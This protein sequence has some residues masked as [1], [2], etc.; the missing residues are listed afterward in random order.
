MGHSALKS[1]V[2][3]KVESGTAAGVVS[4]WM[5]PSGAD[6]AEYFPGHVYLHCPQER[7]DWTSGC[8]LPLAKLI[9]W[10]IDCNICQ[11]SQLIAKFVLSDKW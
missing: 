6:T 3:L 5:G 7:G 1:E 8:D 11:M 2:S 10:A 4:A 9:T